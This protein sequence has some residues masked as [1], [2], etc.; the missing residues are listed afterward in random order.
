MNKEEKPEYAYCVIETGTNRRISYWYV[1]KQDAVAWAN[2][3]KDWYDHVGNYCKVARTLVNLE[4]S[5]D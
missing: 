1:R 3:R 2:K 5:D 4:I